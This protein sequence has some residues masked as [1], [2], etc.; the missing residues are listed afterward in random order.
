MTEQLDNRQKIKNRVVILVM[1][2]IIIGFSYGVNAVL[3]DREW[4]PISAPPELPGF[5]IIENLPP[6][7]TLLYPGAAQRWIYKQ[8]GNEVAY[9]VTVFYQR[10]QQGGELVS[11]ENGFLE[12]KRWQRGP[13]KQVTIMLDK[14]PTR[15]GETIY[16]D[17]GV[18]EITILSQFRFANLTETTAPLL[19]KLY[20]LRS[21]LSGTNGSAE[22][23]VIYPNTQSVAKADAA[24]LKAAAPIL[25]AEIETQI[26]NLPGE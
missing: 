13:E 22:V 3:D 4:V 9:L 11:S 8:Q 16:R 7:F 1:L 15:L 21:E 26:N 19:A 20:G 10:E 6:P 25:F 17:Q 5:L 2:A 12:H 14:G 18:Q 24:F 23:S